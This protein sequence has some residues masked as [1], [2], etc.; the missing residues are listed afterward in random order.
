[1]NALDAMKRKV[2]RMDEA[3]LDKVREDLHEIRNSCYLMLQEL[4][5]LKLNKSSFPGLI[6][7]DTE[8]KR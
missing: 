2:K 7:Q 6:E 4:K 5:K 8:Q 3:Q 1:L